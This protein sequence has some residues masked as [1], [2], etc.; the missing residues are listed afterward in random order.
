MSVPEKETIRQIEARLA[1]SLHLS[2]NALPMTEPNFKSDEEYLAYRAKK[3]KEEA[4]VRWC[5]END[6][7]PADED[8]RER[9]NEYLREMGFF[10]DNMDGEERAGWEDMMT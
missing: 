1:I 9:Y 4:F 7:D 6:E 5:E 3:E 8:L 2:Q 10:W